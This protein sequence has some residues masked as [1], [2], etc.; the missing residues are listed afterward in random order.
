MNGGIELEIDE[1]GDVQIIESKNPDHYCLANMTC[2]YA[3]RTETKK[4]INI[5]C[6]F[7]N[8]KQN[9][10]EFKHCPAKKWHRY[11]NKFSPEIKPRVGCFVCDCKKQWKLKGKNNKWICFNCHPPKNFNKKRIETRKYKIDDTST[12]GGNTHPTL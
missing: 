9:V 12:T 1:D 4:S 5:I 11:V 7:Q 2:K 10:F 6:H 8:K 3:E